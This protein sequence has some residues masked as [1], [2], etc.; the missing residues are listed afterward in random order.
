MNRSKYFLFGLLLLFSHL[1]A[2]DSGTVFVDSGRVD[3]LV[4]SGEIALQAGQFLKADALLDEAL[5]L[6]VKYNRPEKLL[7]IYQKK[8][9]ALMKQGLGKAA[10]TFFEKAEQKALLL[11]HGQKQL[12]SIYLDYGSAYFNTG[13]IEKSTEYIFKAIELFKQ[14]EAWG[15]I[16]AAFL[17]LAINNLG[18]EVFEKAESFA[19]EGL[20]YAQKSQNKTYEAYAYKILTA[21]S[22]ELDQQDSALKYALLS[23]DYWQAVNNPYELGFSNRFIGK[24]LKKKGDV[25]QAIGYLEKSVALFEQIKV[26]DQLIYALLELGDGY[27]D[28]GQKSRGVK[29][30]VA[31]ENLLSKQQ[32]ELVDEQNCFELLEMGYAKAKQF[33]KA[34]FYRKEQEVLK[35]SLLQKERLQSINELETQYEVKEKETK[36]ALQATSLK[37]QRNFIIYI[38]SLIHI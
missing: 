27:L 10:I 25:V 14:E 15:N 35:D 32:L 31:A 18:I 38:L 4:A 8:G 2:Q 11:Q 21:V 19:L 1:P 7:V 22:S 5:S 33:E 9:V 3:T 34:Y 13:A 36:L 28:L 12:S 24:V 37:Q 23:L 6:E 20:K 26:A 16:A 30:L 17:N 29:Q